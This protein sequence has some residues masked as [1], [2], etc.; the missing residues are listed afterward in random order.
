MICMIQQSNHQMFLCTN[1]CVSQAQKLAGTAHGAP[2][3]SVTQRTRYVYLPAQYN[4]RACYRALGGV[5]QLCVMLKINESVARF[6]VTIRPLDSESYSTFLFLMSFTRLPLSS[7]YLF[8]F[9]IVYFLL[10]ISPL[11]FLSSSFILLILLLLSPLFNSCLHFS[12]SPFF[13]SANSL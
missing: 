8:L 1:C 7:P 10:S 3:M 11:S 5:Q 6:R 9:F 12:S 2:S 4:A 13:H